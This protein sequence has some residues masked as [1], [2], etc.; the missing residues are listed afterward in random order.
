VTTT[1]TPIEHSSNTQKRSGPRG[2]ENFR[3]EFRRRAR[4]AAPL[5]EV[6][7][8]DTN[9]RRKSSRPQ[10][11]KDTRSC[12]RKIF[13]YNRKNITNLDRITTG[14][15]RH[16]LC[17]SFSRSTTRLSLKRAYEKRSSSSVPLARKTTAGERA[18]N[19]GG[20]GGTHGQRAAP[21]GRGTCTGLYTLPSTP[22]VVL[23]VVQSDRKSK[24]GSRPPPR[25]RS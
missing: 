16:N 18:N 12:Y 3:R 2:R 6:R 24:R 15:Q 19:G 23:C 9:A 7:V 11:K 10:T 1:T 20:G 21:S 14:L 13:V 5:Y 4:G 8:A 17:V 25:R 22:F